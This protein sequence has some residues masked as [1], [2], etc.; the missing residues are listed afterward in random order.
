[1]P[2]SFRAVASVQTAPRGTGALSARDVKQTVTWTRQDPLFPARRFR[3]FKGKS[4]RRLAG[5]R[6]ATVLADGCG[7]FGHARRRPKE[8]GRVAGCHRGQ[9]RA[10]QRGGCD[11]VG[12]SLA[13]NLA[14]P[15]RPSENGNSTHRLGNSARFSPL[16]DGCKEPL[17]VPD[18]ICS[19]GGSAAHLFTGEVTGKRSRQDRFADAGYPVLVLAGEVEEADA[20][21][22]ST[23]PTGQGTEVEM[24]TYNTH[25]A[26]TT[27]TDPLTK[28]SRRGKRVAR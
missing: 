22:M 15:A 21:E 8:K 5:D 28:P 19:K 20:T 2:Y 12:L 27:G 24:N 18:A 6:E 13:G 14:S 4:E 7:P 25:C 10:K 16:G 26:E 9:I 1:M 3:K 23:C 17:R 11:I